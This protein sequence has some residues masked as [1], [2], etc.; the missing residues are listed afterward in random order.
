MNKIASVG[1][2]L[3]LLAAIAA[4]VAFLSGVG[5]T[6][7]WTAAVF[8][9]SLLVG[10]FHPGDKTRLQLMFGSIGAFL[11]VCAIAFSWSWVGWVPVGI[12]AFLV[13]TMKLDGGDGYGG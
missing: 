2:P 8:G 1:A 7:G 10:A 5:L 9:V 4:G 6:F 12:C 3:A 13:L 11:A